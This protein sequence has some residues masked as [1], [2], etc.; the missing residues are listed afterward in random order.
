MKK[1]GQ[2]PL[3]PKSSLV[4]CSCCGARTARIYDRFPGLCDVCARVA[5]AC[6]NPDATLDINKVHGLLFASTED[7]KVVIHIFHEAGFQEAAGVISQ[8]IELLENAYEKILAVLDAQ[9]QAYLA[10]LEE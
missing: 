5:Y 10:T 9:E 3:D 7:M 8:A 2:T 4:L 1:V 6:C